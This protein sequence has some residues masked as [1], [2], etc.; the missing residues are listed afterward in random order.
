MD[1]VV[2]EIFHLNG[3]D[4]AI[5]HL[6]PYFRHF[7]LR[8]VEEGNGIS[9]FE[10]PRLDPIPICSVKR[11]CGRCIN[12]AHS[13][14]LR[15]CWRDVRAKLETNAMDAMESVR[16]YPG[17]TLVSQGAGLFTAR[18][19]SVANLNEFKALEWIAM[20]IALLDVGQHVPFKAHCCGPTRACCRGLH[21]LLRCEQALVSVSMRIKP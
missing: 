4:F 1:K 14:Q 7:G 20:L 19:H 8:S 5:P 17:D 6:S 11:M 16:K 15:E 18:E 10:I 13:W 21:C 12:H 2:L 3:E 9:D